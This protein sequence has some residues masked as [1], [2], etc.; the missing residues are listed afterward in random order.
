MLR[1]PPSFKRTATLSPSTTLFRSRWP[2]DDSTIAGEAQQTQGKSLAVPDLPEGWSSNRAE[3]ETRA[4][5]EVWSIG[6][7]TPGGEYLALDQGVE[8]RKSTRLN[9]SH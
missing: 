7:L 4:G 9:S 3:I 2:V 8:D 5:V 1:R 6:F